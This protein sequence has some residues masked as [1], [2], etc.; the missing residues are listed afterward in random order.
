[1]A[2]NIHPD[3]LMPITTH[4]GPSALTVADLE[5]SIT[6]YQ[7]TLGLHI[8]ARTEQM[9]ITGT[10]SGTVLLTLLQQEGATPAPHNTTGLYHIALL[11][12]TRIDL[13]LTLL[14]L[15]EHNHP[16][17]GMSDHLV[18]EALYLSDPDGN[19]LEIYRD[20]PR[21]TWSW[22]QG[23]VKMAVDPLNIRSLLAEGQLQKHRPTGLPDGTTTGHVHLRVGD[24]NQAEQFYHGMLGFAITQ[25]MPGALFVAAGGYHHHLGLNVWQS[26]GASRPSLTHAGLR[27]FTVEV[28]DKGYIQQLQ[29]RLQCVEW[30]ARRHGQDLII[31][32]PWQNA[33]V[34]TNNASSS[35]PLI[36]DSVLTALR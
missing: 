4:M 17:D 35:D 9:A 15:I 34:I 5:R 32:D 14:R 12:P 30:P 10:R 13:A 24:I 25:R 3:A 11:L 33:I 31:H 28:P 22:H 18:S 16:L 27:F 8:L 19:G 7:H 1:M 26:R 29:D 36:A 21:E 20:R 2:T 6:F 23:L